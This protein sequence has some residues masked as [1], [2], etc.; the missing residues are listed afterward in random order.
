MIED[1]DNSY[2]SLDCSLVRAHQQAATGKGS[3]G[4]RRLWGVPEVV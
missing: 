1:P 2:V 3:K 4:G